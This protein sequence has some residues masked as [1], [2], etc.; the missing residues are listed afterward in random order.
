MQRVWQPRYTLTNLEG[1][2][3][4]RLGQ[5]L[6]VTGSNGAALPPYNSVDM[7]TWPC[8][9]PLCLLQRKKSKLKT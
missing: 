3:Q 1:G 9:A 8:W 7:G 2:T 4:Q 5:S 6:L